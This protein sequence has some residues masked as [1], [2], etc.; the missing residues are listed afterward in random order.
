[1]S[2]PALLWDGVLRRLGAEMPAFAVEAW[3][4][5]LVPEIGSEGLVL[6]CPTPFHRERVRVRYLPHIA[7]CAAVE[8]GQPLPVS[9][10]VLSEAPPR[11]AA[12]KPNAG[13]AA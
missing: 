10:T 2:R 6:S 9:L 4:R 5:P 8:A 7:R 11:E 1:M 12:A 3:M 13:A